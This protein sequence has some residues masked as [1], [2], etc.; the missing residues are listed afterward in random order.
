MVKKLHNIQ[1]LNKK[2]IYKYEDVVENTFKMLIKS[3][4]AEFASFR[5]MFEHLNASESIKFIK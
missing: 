4:Q 1:G 2:D 3:L 5:N